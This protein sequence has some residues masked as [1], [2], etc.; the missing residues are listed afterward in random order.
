[1]STKSIKEL[2]NSINGS[3]TIESKLIEEEIIEK[4]SIDEDSNDTIEEEVIDEPNE[5]DA[6]NELSKLEQ[7]TKSGYVKDKKLNSLSEVDKMLSSINVDLTNIKIVDDSDIFK[8]FDNLDKIT[9][10]PTFEVVALQSGY[11]ASFKSLNNNGM[12]RARKISGTEYE[13]TM[14]LL[15]LIH[16]HIETTSVGSVPFKEW[17]RLTSEPDFETLAYGLYCATYNKETDYM[18]TCPK[19]NRTNTVKVS[20]EALLE[21]K[22]PKAYE[23]IQT[24]L[25]RKLTPQQL[26]K[27]SVL[28]TKDRIILP[29]SKCIIDISLPS[30]QDNLESLSKPANYPNVEPE[31]FGYMKYI[32]KFMII[33]L[34][35]LRQ[36]TVQYI[37]LTRLEDI[38]KVIISLSKADRL[39][40]EEKLTVK[41]NTYRIEYKI[42]E[43]NCTGCGHT[44]SSLPVSSIEILF[45]SIAL[46]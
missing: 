25:S 28:N 33:D 7:L 4:F 21:V 26:L 24:L 30:L 8:T 20:K 14:K 44:I 40:L 27:E 10:K 43:F 13:Q 16:E 5:E 2:N 37:H 1:M 29:E 35:A 34:E 46:E 36:G 38:L 18:I 39:V 42:P 22:D 31:I 41:R 32:D 15:K 23:Y 6:L 3:G 45:Q 9:V 12:I 11:R 19:C 17:L